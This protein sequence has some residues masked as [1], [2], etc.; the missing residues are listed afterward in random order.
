MASLLE[1]DPTRIK[2]PPGDGAAV[3]DRVPDWVA[4]GT[5]APL[6]TDLEALVG[7][8]QVLHRAI[9]L[10]KYASDA[11]PYRLI[12][13]VV[14]QPRDASDVAKL[15]GYARR[16]GTPITL[17]AGGT[18]LNGQ[19]QGDGILVDVRAKFGRIDVQD[20]G[21]TVRVQPGALL[22][23]I[24]AFLAR[25]QR[26]LGPDPASAAFATIGGVI[27]NN[28]GG[29]RCGTTED[30]YST[31]RALRFVLPSGTEV[32]SA[33]PDAEERFA[34][35]EPDLAAGLLAIRD[36]IR[37]DEELVARIRHKFAIKNTTGYRLIAFLDADTP[38]QIL[39]RLLVGS[40]GTLGFIAEAELDTVAVPP[41]ISTAML[42][43]E[44]IDAAAEAVPSLVATG[45]TA[46]ELMV[47]VT[48]KAATFA[49][50]GTPPEWA[51]LPDESAALLVEV[52]ADDEVSLAAREV[53]A[54]D[55]LEGR[56]LVEK[57][58]FTRDRETSE[59]WWTVREGMFGFVGTMRPQGTSLMAEDV[60]VRRSASP[61]RPRTSWACSAS[62]G[63]WSASPATP[64]RATCTSR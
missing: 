44:N 18:S 1:P 34:A 26:R 28:S 46:V 48:L 61:R 37:A 3:S 30:P 2:A 51:Q 27:A 57:A 25:E 52:G 15:L 32:D 20:G 29:M 53:A 60:C 42:I 12:P 63:S 7:A 19:G 41:A 45:A 17:R 62:T 22:G 13:K 36:E 10:V 4:T 9:D 8:D 58:A 43:F 64:R 35:A 54:L 38:V 55:A 5:P 50:P 23:T 11:S 47:S 16:T 59:L 31:T 21:A 56:P 24:N 49:F 6:R 33:A 39:R 40:E 14:V